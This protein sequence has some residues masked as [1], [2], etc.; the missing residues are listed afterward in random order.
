MGITA[1]LWQAGALGLLQRRNWAWW[2]VLGL[3][4]AA[5]EFKAVSMV[6]KLN[7]SLLVTFS[8]TTILLLLLKSVRTEFRGSEAV[9]QSFG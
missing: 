8:L 4:G 3:N 2:L 9:K 5:L 7:E 1:L 6:L